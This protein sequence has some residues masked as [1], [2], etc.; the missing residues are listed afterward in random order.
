M[1][2]NQKQTF[3]LAHH[4]NISQSKKI[5][6]MCVIQRFVE[7]RLVE[8]SFHSF[9]DLVLAVYWYNFDT[10]NHVRN[11]KTQSNQVNGIAPLV[12]RLSVNLSREILDISTT[13][14]NIG[15]VFEF[16]PSHKHMWQ[17]GNAID[18]TVENWI[19]CDAI[20][21]VYK[22]SNF[23]PNRSRIKIFETLV[24]NTPSFL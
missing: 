15:F 16:F 9:D 10:S 17:I 7:K 3:F 22:W 11:T 20:K 2:T 12:K 5:A 21:Y 24:A 14:F 19:E 23:Q 8:F 4:L 6:R 1:H 13:N 18:G